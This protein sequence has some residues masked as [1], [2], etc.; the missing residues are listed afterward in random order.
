MARSLV[1]LVPVTL[2]N[3]VVGGVMGRAGLSSRVPWRR[4]D[5]TGVNGLVDQL[6][7]RFRLLSAMRH[8]IWAWGSPAR[9]NLR[10][11]SLFR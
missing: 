9:G 11:R 4:Q 2:G 7:V 5:L 3:I 6:A 10:E 1:N 8:R